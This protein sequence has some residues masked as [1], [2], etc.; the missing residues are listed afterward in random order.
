MFLT[1]SLGVG[2]GV[3][4]LIGLARGTRAGLAAIAGT[5]LGAVLIDLWNRPLAAWIRETLRPELP[6]LPTFLLIAA[7]FLLTVAIIGYGGSALLPR[8]PAQSRSRQIL[9]RIVGGLLGALNGALIASYLLRYADMARVNGDVADL[10]ATSPLAQVLLLW[11]PWFIL[12]LVATTG[13]I[14]LIRG[15]ARFVRARRT[16]AT[17]PAASTAQPAASS[18]TAGAP[19]PREPERSSGEATMDQALGKK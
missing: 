15:G 19:P 7:V 18:A 8:A 1:V 5:L 17:A 6:A 4:G 12:A 11:L 10:V 16:A 2:I 13:A 3:L 14:V 9:D